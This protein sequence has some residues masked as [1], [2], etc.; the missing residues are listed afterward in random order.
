[1]SKLYDHATSQ[2]ENKGEQKTNEP[3]P[4]SDEDRAK[5]LYG[6][7][8]YAETESALIPETSL[9]ATPEQLQQARGEVRAAL[10][11][12]E[13]PAPLAKQLTEQFFAA[14][15]NPISDEEHAAARTTMHAELTARF[16][17]EEACAK[18]KDV[19]DLLAKSEHIANGLVNAGLDVNTEV[20]VALAA[21][22][23]SQRGRG[24]L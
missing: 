9:D 14:M 18:L 17:A 11:A 1:V 12:V 13:L 22:A 2:P 4:K 7:T 16:G 10:H 24:R 15:A 19:R 8:T 5:L 6:E 3:A 20:I 21:H 23:R